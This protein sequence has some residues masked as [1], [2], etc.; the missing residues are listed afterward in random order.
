MRKIGTLWMALI[1]VIALAGC[2]SEAEMRRQRDADAAEQ[3]DR[4]SPTPDPSAA[5]R[6][7]RLTIV[8]FDGI[9][10]QIAKHKGQVVVMD[11]WSTSC[12]PCMKEFH[13]LVE[14]AQAIQ[15]RAGGLHFAELR[16]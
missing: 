15:P 5:E 2:N 9:Q 3:A 1:T 8:D 12:P 7:V 4:A 11:A 13:N 6:A 16:L 14:L 10:Q